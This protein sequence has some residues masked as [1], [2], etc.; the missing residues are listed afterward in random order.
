MTQQTYEATLFLSY[1]LQSADMRHPVGN[2]ISRPLLVSSGTRVL[3]S[4]RLVH[5]LKASF[6]PRVIE[7]KVRTIKA[8]KYTVIAQTRQPP[9]QMRPEL[10]HHLIQ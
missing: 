2:A 9:S 1:T 7:S 10:F 6:S 8:I 4:R 5:P 3:N